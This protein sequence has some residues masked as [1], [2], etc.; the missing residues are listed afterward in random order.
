[1]IV[2]DHRIAGQLAAEL[3]KDV[4][5]EILEAYCRDLGRLCREIHDAA[6]AARPEAFRQAAHAM[7]GASASVGA[8]QLEELARRVLHPQTNGAQDLQLLAA[9]IQEVTHRTVAELRVLAHNF[10]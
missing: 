6:V 8:V 1:M 10:Q 7:A 2:I 5:R 9:Q 4:F 3:P